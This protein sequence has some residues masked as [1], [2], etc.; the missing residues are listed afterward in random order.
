MSKLQTPLR[1]GEQKAVGFPSSTE[2]RWGRGNTTP[3][4]LR[5]S[6]RLAGFGT[7]G[8]RE[9]PPS[10]A[11]PPAQR[12]G[13]RQVRR[14][15]RWNPFPMG[16]WWRTD[17][18]SCSCR[19]GRKGEET[20]N[21]LPKRCEEPPCPGAA[22]RVLL[23]SPSHHRWAGGKRREAGRKVEEHQAAWLQLEPLLSPLHNF[24]IFSAITTGF[25]LRIFSAAS[26]L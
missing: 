25:S 22:S 3:R 1:R 12:P 17:P 8:G 11:L 10:K 26:A 4:L 15:G 5:G 13:G 24:W 14:S 9:K 2:R 20:L 23:E 19:A 6:G 16:S 21:C 18:L 7:A